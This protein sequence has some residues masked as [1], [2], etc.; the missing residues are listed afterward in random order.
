[1][2]VLHVQGNVHVVDSL[3]QVPAAKREEGDC[4]SAPGG[5]YVYHRSKG[6]R[7]VCMSANHQKLPNNNVNM[8]IEPLLFALEDSGEY[9]CVACSPYYMLPLL[10]APLACSP[11]M[12][13]CRY[14]DRALRHYEVYTPRR[15][16]GG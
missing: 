9:E 8:Y 11:Y 14:Y 12:L 7:T 2:L 3:S 5:K 13:L 1:M 6:S 15:R 16:A 4:L 10:H